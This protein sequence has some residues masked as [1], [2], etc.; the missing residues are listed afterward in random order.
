MRR[1]D[2]DDSYLYGE[3]NAE[4]PVKA[5]V[6]TSGESPVGHEEGFKPYLFSCTS[7]ICA[8]EILIIIL[9]PV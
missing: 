7:S 6:Q 2:D 5:D 9:Q 1:M 8:M 3:S 4:E